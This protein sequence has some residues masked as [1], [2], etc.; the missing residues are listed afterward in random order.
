MAT[1]YTKHHNT[2]RKAVDT[3]QTQPAPGRTDQVVNNAGGY[4]FKLSNID[5]IKRFLILGSEGGTYYVGEQELTKENASNLI[6]AI[7]QDGVGV[8]HLITEI[9]QAG[10]APKNDPAI[11]ALAL[12]CT[13]GNEETKKAAYAAVTKVC[14]TGTHLFQFAESIKDL[15][16]WS[17]GLRGGVGKFYTARPD[18]KLAMQL[19]KYR[20]RNGW[21]HKDMLRLAHVK[22]TSQSQAQLLRWAVGKSGEVN[23]PVINAFEEIQKLGKSNIN[24]SIELLTKNNLPW[25]AV[26]TELLN[27]PKVWEA[28]LSNDMPLTALIRNLGKMTSIG[29]LSGV[30]DSVKTVVNALHNEENLKSARVHPLAILIALSTYG[31]GH[32]FKGSLSWKPVQAVS[33]A[34]DDAFYLAFQTV[35]PAGK[36]YFLGLDVS[37][38]MGCTFGQ[39]PLTC[40]EASTAMA[41]VTHRTE[42]WTFVG[43]FSTGIK[44]IPLSKK[45]TLKS[46][47][48]YTSSIN[49]G[50]TDCALPMQYATKNKLEVDTFVVYTDNETYAGNGHPFQAL[51]EYR[52]KLG[53]DA[54]LVVVGMASTGFTIADPNDRGMLDVV[55]FDTATPGIISSFSNGEV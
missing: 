14:R 3:P 35:I 10:R 33:D 21:T 44:E 46:A 8:V 31:A 50:G 1:K 51:K 9:S 45:D 5:Q 26:P 13:Y 40:C 30:N 11:F 19:I 24:R 7:K 25:E 52:Q 27:E 49:F 4:V 36:N 53:R 2:G 34:L 23:N 28:L 32:G 16:G 42:P 54:K 41:L 38:S 37:G 15:R 20:Q 47:M 39:S 12:A 29:V 43:A 17:R 6:E 55:G 18:D 48:K 22:P